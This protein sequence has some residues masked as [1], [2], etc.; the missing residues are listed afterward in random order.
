MTSLTIDTKVI[1]SKLTK[2][3]IAHNK[4]FI[5]PHDQL[6]EQKLFIL[7]F[8]IEGYSYLASSYLLVLDE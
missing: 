2:M 3:H 5:Q 7:F 4:R 1:K 6:Q 8:E